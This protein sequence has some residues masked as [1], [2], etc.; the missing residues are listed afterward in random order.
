M[1]QHNSEID[2]RAAGPNMSHVLTH[3]EFLAKPNAGIDPEYKLEIR[4]IREGAAPRSQL[5]NPTNDDGLEMALYFVDQTN[6]QGFNVYVTVNPS[7]P[8]GPHVKDGDIIQISFLFA[9]ADERG[10]VSQ[11]KSDFIHK[12]DAYVC[13]GTKPFERGHFYWQLEEPVEPT[14]FEQWKE[15]MQNIAKRHGCDPQICNPSRIMRL[16]GTVSYPSKAKRARGY[17]IELTAFYEY[18]GG[19]G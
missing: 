12:P 16:G 6:R 4:A 11:V 13:T 8:S 14:D 5:I 1:M 18:G 9:D 3:L 7:R 19:H 15:L 17:Q 2:V 10:V